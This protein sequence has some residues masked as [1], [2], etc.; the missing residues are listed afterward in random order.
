MAMGKIR[1]DG[2]P[3]GR[4]G[5]I[6]LLAFG[7]G[8]LALWSVGD[9]R[10]WL[11]SRA[12]FVEG[13]HNLGFADEPVRYTYLFTDGTYSN[14]VRTL[15]VLLPLVAVALFLVRRHEREQSLTFP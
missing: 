13:G 4:I 6:G 11:D 14:S 12:L 10:F 7:V 3:V 15:S 9:V 2:G 1:A 5:G 8:A